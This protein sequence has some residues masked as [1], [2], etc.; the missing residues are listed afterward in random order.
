MRHIDGILDKLGFIKAKHDHSIY[1]MSHQEG[2]IFLL[3]Q[4]D[5]FVLACRSEATSIDIF[6]WIGLALQRPIEKE[7]NIVPFTKLGLVNDFNG[8][9]IHQCKEYIEISAESYIDRLLKTHGWDTPS[10]KSKDPK[11]PPVPIPSTGIDSMYKEMGPLDHTV[12]HAVLEKANNFKY[13]TLLGELMYAY[14]TCCPD[15]GYAVTTLSKFAS[16]PSQ[17]HYTFLKGVAKYL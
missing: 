11:R 8:I 14:V 10:A 4:V 2:D 15:I 9:D 3:Q 6:D 5:D 7:K 13:R 1:R 16:K 12:K 17:V